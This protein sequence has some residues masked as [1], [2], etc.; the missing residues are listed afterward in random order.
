MH[1]YITN[2]ITG[3]K[4][5][6]LEILNAKHI[7]LTDDEVR[8]IV[9]IE[10]HPEVSRWLTIYVDND[11]EREFQS[12]KRF[13]RDL[14]K[15]RDVEV[16]IAKYDGRVAGFLALWRLEEYMEHVASVGISV[17]P[18]CW[19]KGVATGLIRSAIELAREK[20]FKRL[21]I[22]TVAENLGMRRAAERMGFKLEGIRPKR[23][24][25]G[26][27]YYDEAAYFLLLDDAS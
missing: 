5:M 25:K 2:F 21:E 13:F 7:Q 18:D 22:E 12:Y 20:G 8:Q 27:T 19:R 26:G 9:E 11:A 6:G 16:L 23:L 14:C 3:E 17:H 24:L 4:W 10:Q 15:K 1:S